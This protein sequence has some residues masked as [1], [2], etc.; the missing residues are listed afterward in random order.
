MKILIGICTGGTIHAQTVVSLIGAL[1]R[2]KEEQIDFT[3]S[4]Q[5]GG[6][7][8][9]SMNRLVE[10][11]KKGGFDY[12]MSIDCDMIF[13]KDG[14]IRLLDNHKDI[15]GANYSVRG[16]AVNG[17]P[18]EAVVK[19]VDENGKKLNLPLSSLPKSLFKCFSLGNGFTLYKMSVFDKIPEP[20]FEAREDENGDFSTEDVHFMA[21]AY[22]VGIGVWC[23]P[24]IK[25]GHIGTFNYEV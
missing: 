20:W 21:K 11:A 1:D 6:Y 2:L 7:K 12:Y 17:N 3:V 13:P 24:Q 23:N 16:T 15:V 4:I 9:A 18:R 22:E 8:Q 19:V 25:I 14:I 5:I 10:Q